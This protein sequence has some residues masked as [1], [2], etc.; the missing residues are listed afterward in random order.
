[1][2]V[3]IKSNTSTT[4]VLT[5]SQLSSIV[6]RSRSVTKCFQIENTEIYSQKKRK[7]NKKI[8]YV[9]SEVS[10][11]EAKTD[12]DDE[13]FSAIVEQED[14]MSCCSEDSIIESI[15]DSY[16]IVEEN[17]KN[18]P[19]ISCN[20][21]FDDAHEEWMSNKKIGP[22]GNYIYI[23]GYHLK[24]GKKCQRGCVDKIG[25]YGGCKSHYMWEEK[26]NKYM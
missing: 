18:G 21:D 26:Q 17:K 6:L 2:F 19:I 7:R 15:P 4:M 8:E 10:I 3:G 25:L 14:N 5:R 22:Y 12:S 11:N 1:M 20:I 24:N 16:Y 23:C 9:V 13:H